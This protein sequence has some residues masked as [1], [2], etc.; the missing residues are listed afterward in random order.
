MARQR[1]HKSYRN[2]RGRFG[3]LSK[4]LSVLAV[5]AAV[6]VAFV[7]FFRVNHIEVEGNDRYTAEEIIEASGIQLGDNLVVLP[8][9]RIASSI[10][11][12]LPYVEVVIPQRALPD[13]VILKVTERKAAASINSGEG[14]WLISAQGK[15]LES[16]I[17]NETVVEISGLTAL[18]P[19]AG[20][21]L[22]VAEEE[23]TTLN[24][25]LALLTA[26]EEREMLADCASLDCASASYLGAEYGIYHLR[27]PRGG[28]YDYYL[29]LME[30]AIAH[31]NMP[32]DTPG[33]LDLTVE[34]GRVHFT[35]D[36]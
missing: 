15:L 8:K 24:Y 31:E 7:V 25:V 1:R 16:A 12:K 26:L 10:L 27:L 33:T 21:E 5:A 2:R 18:A 35:A 22:Q 34:D 11:T 13:G 3:T 4:L 17:G 36:K 23:Q 19:Y 29:R 9:G 6:I 14:R 28:D 30:A 20:S 32:K